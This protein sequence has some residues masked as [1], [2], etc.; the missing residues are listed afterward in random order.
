[1]H[2]KRRGLAWVVTPALLLAMQHPSPAGPAPSLTDDLS[3]YA[4]TRTDS[5][6]VGVFDER[7]HW[8]FWFRPDAA[9]DN[10]SIVKVNVL[11]TLL[12]QAQR[13][14]RWLTPWEQQ[15]SR[16]MIRNSDNTAASALWQQV[17][18]AAG[19]AAYDHAVGL[20][21]TTFDPGGAWGL[22]RSVV[23][24][25][26]VLLRAVGVGAG[27]LS[28]RSRAYARSQM[29]QVESD[30]RWGVSAGAPS[31]ATVELKNGWLPRQTDQWRINSIGHIRD[32]REDCDIV[33]LSTK[34]VSMAY[35]VATAEGV[36][37][38]VRTHLARSR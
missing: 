2:S 37:R 15:Q 17:G 34:N 31:G 18:R 19:V 12:W 21:A 7:H 11:E 13:A 5:F 30:Q 4:A 33:F 36:T 23:R 29:S 16:L 6:S 24:D 27:P 20:R 3:R 25:Q 8:A 35:G 32:D 9:Y 28:A 1:V 14:H 38:I 22:T 10:A 26:I